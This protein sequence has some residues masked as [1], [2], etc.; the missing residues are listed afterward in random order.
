MNRDEFF[1]RLKP[2]LSQSLAAFFDDFLIVTFLKN[3]EFFS[4]QRYYPG[5]FSTAAEILG[6]LLRAQRKLSIPPEFEIELAMA[7]RKCPKKR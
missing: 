6:D 3:A 7:R 4:R 5:D 2:K 1:R